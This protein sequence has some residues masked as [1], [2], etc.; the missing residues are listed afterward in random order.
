VALDM[1]CDYIKKTAECRTRLSEIFDN[2]DQ[3]LR[4][5]A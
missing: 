3:S 4:F 5:T 1:Y 2:N